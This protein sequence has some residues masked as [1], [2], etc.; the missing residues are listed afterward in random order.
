MI[1]GESI[2]VEK[3]KGCTA[4]G[5]TVNKNGVLRIKATKIGSDT[6]L[7]QI[8]NLV[9]DAQISKVPIQRMADKVA[10]Y[11]VP[12]VVIASILSFAVWYYLG[13]PFI[14][15]FTI[16]I[17]ILIIACPC[18]LGMATPIAILVGKGKGA[19]NGILIK[20]G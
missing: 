11:F 10:S 1:T 14:F 8:I 18:A 19:E 3:I 13:M 2:P 17:S 7:S 15:A 6:M 12:S 16:M 5:A 9:E 4:I 20:N